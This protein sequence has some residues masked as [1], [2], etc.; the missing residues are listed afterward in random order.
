MGKPSKPKPGNNVGGGF[1]VFVASDGAIQVKPGDSLSKYSMAMY[2]DFDHLY[3]FARKIPPGSGSLQPIE[4]V[5]FIKANETLYHWPTATVE[6]NP[7]AADIR[8]DLERLLRERYGFKG[9]TL[10][11]AVNFLSDQAFWTRMGIGAT[12]IVTVGA[13]GLL[14]NVLGVG[15]VEAA[16]ASGIMAGMGMGLGIAAAVLL[17]IGSLLMIWKNASVNIRD[18]GLRGIAYGAVAYTF[19]DPKPQFPA[20]LRQNLI[21]SGHT[22]PEEI[23]KNVRAFNTAVAETMGKLANERLPTGVTREQLRFRRRL[24]I[25]NR[26]ALG[27]LLMNDIADRSFGYKVDKDNFLWALGVDPYEPPTTTNRNVPDIY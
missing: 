11:R 4:N 7:P 15:T 17:P 3:E 16:T 2:G 9:S 22:P 5:N 13:D 10:S 14:L 19:E 25:G 27:T 26:K 12:Q 8:E 1:S 20:K 18:N 6:F 24:A 21:S 23:D